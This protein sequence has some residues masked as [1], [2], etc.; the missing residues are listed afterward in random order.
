[1]IKPL[2]DTYQNQAKPLFKGYTKATGQNTDDM[3][4]H[5]DE[6]ISHDLIMYVHYYTDAR[7]SLLN[8]TYFKCIDNEN[9]FD[10]GCM[11]NIKEPLLQDDKC[12]WTFFGYSPIAKHKNYYLVNIK[13]KACGSMIERFNSHYLFDYDGKKLKIS[14]TILASRYPENPIN[15]YKVNDWGFEYITT[16]C[17]HREISCRGQ[18]ADWLSLSYK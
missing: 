12:D 3:M 17:Y 10:I 4:R 9:V 2:T 8:K 16:G 14:E 13:E 11:K 1:M 6:I 7:L 15:F 5:Q 18:R